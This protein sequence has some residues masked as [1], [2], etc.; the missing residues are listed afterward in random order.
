MLCGYHMHEEGIAMKG[1]SR[2]DSPK[3]HGWLARVYRDQKEYPKLFSDLKYGGKGKALKLAQAYVKKMERALPPSTRKEPPPFLLSSKPIHSNTTGI[4]GVSRLTERHGRKMDWIGYAVSGKVDGKPTN[5]RFLFS[6]Y[7]GK[8]ATLNA[9]AA[10]R[11]KLER[12]MMQEWKALV[13]KK[14]KKT[15]TASKTKKSKTVKRTSRRK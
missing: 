5:K 14:T 8:R 9:A 15:A 7:A 1:V 6:Q 10:Y 3:C 2:I 4:N 12:L 13:A 11:K